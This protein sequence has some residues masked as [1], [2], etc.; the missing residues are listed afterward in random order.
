MKYSKRFRVSRET[1]GNIADFESVLYR[2]LVSD[3]VNNM[4]IKDLKKLFTM[5]KCDPE[6][7]NIKERTID[8]NISMDRTDY[9]KKL[10]M[11]NAVEYTVWINLYGDKISNN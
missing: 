6:S 11:E 7:H 2:R 8:S 1:I 4:D 10:K 9:L 3:L 5:D